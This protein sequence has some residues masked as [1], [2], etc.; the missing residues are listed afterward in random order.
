[1]KKNKNI[2][3]FSKV[4]VKSN[5]R[6]CCDGLIFKV[7][8]AVYYIA[9]AYSVMMCIAMMIGC[10]LTMSEYAAKETADAASKYNESLTQFWSMAVSVASTVLCIVLLKLKVSI[11]F[12]V[13]GC[14]NCFIVFAVFYGASVQNDI[15]N[16]GQT[17]F[18]GTFGVPSILLAALSLTVGVLMFVDNRRINA[19]YEKY[20]SELYAAYSEN[21]AKA[22]SAEEFDKIMDNYKGEELFR[23]DIPLKKSLRKRKAKQDKQM[24]GLLKSEAEENDEEQ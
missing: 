10:A 8:K 3:S 14:V 13:A 24:E 2:L 1:M 9:A 19:A 17:V 20:T 22:I 12:A 23:T 11:P 5:S 21:G 18:W 4:F 7:I 6:L 15:Q 16:G